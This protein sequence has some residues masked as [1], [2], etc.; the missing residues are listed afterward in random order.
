MSEAYKTLEQRFARLYALREAAGMLHWDSAVL[1]PSGGAEARSEHLAALEVTCHEMLTDPRLAELFATAADDAA[2]LDDWQQ[3]NLREMRREWLHATAVPS[4]LVEAMSR[5]TRSCEMVWREA[6]PASD[7]ARVKPYLADVLA[8]VREEG[9]AKGDALG[10]APYDALLDQYEPDGQSAR[11][12]V[13]FEDIA[14]FLPGFLQEVLDRQAQEPAPAVPAGPFPQASQIALAERLMQGVG[15]DFN[16]GRLD[17]SLHPFCGG[18]ADDVRIT[19]RYDESDFTSAIMGVLH[20]TGHALYERGLPAA[21]RRQPV[22]EARGMGLHESQ[23]LLIEMQACRSPEFIGHL[24]PIARDAFGGEGAA[25]SPGN[26]RRLYTHVEP[27]HIRVDAD[28]VTYPAHV[29]LRYRL[30]KALVAGDMELDD[31]PA[32]WNEGMRNLLGIQPPDDRLGCLQ[33]IHW[34]DGGWGYFPTYTLGAMAAAQLFDAA[35]RAVPGIPE[36]LARGDFK[37]LLGW[38]RENVHGHGSRFSTDEVLEHA[39]G[40]P[41]DPEVFKAHLRQRYLPN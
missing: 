26:L 27:G 2:E 33:D 7:F 25:W 31:L 18:V 13:I 15:F 1:M 23:S 9:Q 14:A 4:R 29:I 34:Y 17:V 21:W 32:A 37:P 3:A 8:L 30:E 22:G 10:V 38:L 12:D 28:E 11:I 16:Y 41:L 6:R 20:E 24:A 36:A 5:A 40:K 39:T 19:T 35:R